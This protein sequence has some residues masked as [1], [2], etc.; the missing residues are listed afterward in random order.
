MELKLSQK[1]CIQ[2]IKDLDLTPEVAPELLKKG[3]RG[4]QNQIIGAAF[5]IVLNDGLDNEIVEE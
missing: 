5:R 1:Q 3:N 2:F 4:L